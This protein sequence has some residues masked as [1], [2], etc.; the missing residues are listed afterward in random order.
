MDEGWEKADFRTL[1]AIALLIVVI[2]LLTTASCG[3]HLSRENVQCSE[4]LEG[5][6]S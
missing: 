3:G 4:H 1:L 6:S 5:D 2:V